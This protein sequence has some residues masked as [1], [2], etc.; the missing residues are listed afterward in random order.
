MTSLTERITLRRLLDDT[1]IVYRNNTALKFC[2]VD[3]LSA[4]QHLFLSPRRCVHGLHCVCL[5]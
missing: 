1:A 3:P 2:L 4:I 5:R